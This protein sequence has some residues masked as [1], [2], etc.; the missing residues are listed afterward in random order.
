MFQRIL[1]VLENEQVFQQAIDHA[2]ELAQRMDAEV[3]LLMVVEMAFM[4]RTWLGG[5][6]NAI[7]ELEQRAGRLLAGISADFLEA[8][9]ATSAALRAGDPAQE[10]IKFLAERP[11]FQVAIWGSHQELP[12]GPKRHWM[13]K[14]ASS[15]ECPLWTVGSRNP[16]ATQS[17]ADA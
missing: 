6:R 2:R 13:A 10:L 7:N 12:G 14:V 1:V 11:P 8:G 9:V 4:D 3:T 15:L 16:Q 17:G 5:K